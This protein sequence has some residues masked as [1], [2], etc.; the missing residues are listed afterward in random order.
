MRQHHQPE[1]WR[2]ERKQVL[3]EE[4]QEA[5]LLKDYDNTLLGMLNDIRLRDPEACQDIIVETLFKCFARENRATRSKEEIFL[6]LDQLEALETEHLETSSSVPDT[7]KR[8]MKLAR[9]QVEF[10]N[11]VTLLKKTRAHF[12]C[13]RIECMIINYID[14]HKGEHYCMSRS[15]KEQ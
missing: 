6:E 2:L 9:E 10:E 13:G 14:K 15:D 5:H 3:S 4:E 11:Y 1:I 12:G 8:E 7:L